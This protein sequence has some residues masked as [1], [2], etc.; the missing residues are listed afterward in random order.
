[1]ILADAGGS[2]SYRSRVL[3]AQL[4]A[5]SDI[6]V[7]PITVCHYPPGCSNWNPIEHHLFNHISMNWAGVPLRTFETMMK[8][9]EGTAT[10]TG[11]QV[12]AIFKRGGNEL[13]ERVSNEE[14]RAPSIGPHAACPA[15]NYTIR[16]RPRCSEKRRTYLLL[17]PKAMRH[18]RLSYP[19]YDQRGCAAGSVALAR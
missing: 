16:P 9:I 19:T 2:N 11:L 13:G 12:K 10:R 1:L 4:Q 14:M 3:K 8:Y 5:L 18:D 15:W 17:S 6:A 7:L